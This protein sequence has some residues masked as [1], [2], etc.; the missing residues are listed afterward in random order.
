MC[1]IFA[2]K[3]DELDAATAPDVDGPRTTSTLLSAMYFWASA[4][5]GAGPCSTGVSPRTNLTFS[6]SGFASLLTANFAHA[7]C[8]APRNPA[9]PVTGVTSGSVIVLLQ[10]MLA[11]E[12]AAILGLPWADAATTV[13]A[14]TARARPIAFFICF[15]LAKTLSRRGLAL[16]RVS[17][18]LRPV[19]MI[20]SP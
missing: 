1:A 14:S 6:P 13:V 3:Y 5:A 2:W 15:L 12:A 18:L 19:S 10:L 16:Y 4:C 20:K 8:S 9:P 11:A 17:T 7:P